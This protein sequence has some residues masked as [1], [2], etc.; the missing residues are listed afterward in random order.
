MRYSGRIVVTI[1]EEM[2]VKRLVRPRRMTVRLTWRGC[3]AQ[4]ARDRL[5]RGCWCRLPDTWALAHR[6][7]GRHLALTEARGAPPD[8]LLARWAVED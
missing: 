2:S 3:L 1:S 5:A 6:L 7:V 4:R 8:E